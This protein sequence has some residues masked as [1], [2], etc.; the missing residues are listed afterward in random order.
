MDGAKQ[1]KGNGSKV[2]KSDNCKRQG[3]LQIDKRQVTLF[4]YQLVA[5]NEQSIQLSQARM[6]SKSIISQFNLQI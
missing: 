2:V 4:P 6:D 1:V 3:K 5:F